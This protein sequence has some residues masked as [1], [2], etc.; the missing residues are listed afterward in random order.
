MPDMAV[1]NII[2][3][4]IDS[5]Q[6]EI[7]NNKTNRRQETYGVVKGCAN[8][9]AGLIGKQAANGQNDQ[10]HS[11]KLIN[12][13]YSSKDEVT[14]KRKSSIMTQKIHDTFGNMFNSI[15]CFEGTFSLQLRPD[16]KPYQA[17]PRCIAYALQKPLW[18]ELEHLQKL[19]IIAP[20]GVDKIS[21]WCNSFVLVPK[22]NGKV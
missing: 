7:T 16:S 17:P 19:D 15:V 1:L 10:N 2:N 12:Y 22:V 20:L 14:D 13:F 8:R 21:E 9:D 11:N 18:E 6:A 3:I 4:N 5:I